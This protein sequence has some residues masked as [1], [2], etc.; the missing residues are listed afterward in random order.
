MP[1]A[2]TDALTKWIQDYNA[3]AQHDFW[4]GMTIILGIAFLLILFSRW[5]KN[6]E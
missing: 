3:K 2:G 1:D 5:H 4:L 6:D